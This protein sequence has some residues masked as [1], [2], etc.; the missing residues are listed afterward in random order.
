MSSYKVE[1]EVSN[2]LAKDADTCTSQRAQQAARGGIS[3]GE[4][5][6][7][8]IALRA[9]EAALM[10]VDRVG[11]CGGN[12]G[13]KM[14]PDT[15]L[16]DPAC[17]QLGP[18]EGGDIRIAFANFQPDLVVRGPPSPASVPYRVTD[19]GEQP[20]EHLL[21]FGLEDREARSYHGRA[22]GGSR[23]AVSS[24]ASIELLSPAMI[25]IVE[26]PGNAVGNTK[27]GH[28]KLLRSLHR[29]RKIVAGE[30]R[31][32]SRGQSRV[33]GQWARGRRVP[34]SP[35]AMKDAGYIER[36]D[37]RGTRLSLCPSIVPAPRPR[38]SA[39]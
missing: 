39:G 29:A 16:K 2:I 26:M 23:L 12:V 30:G 18:D 24:L 17:A 28:L 31:G 1:R 37:G 8:W 36:S 3:N 20:R 34:Q 33:R 10:R 9:G 19:L 7:Y 5:H 6:R 35:R 22:A 27:L 21:K 11:R 32:Q 15:F 4:A 25:E 13:A 38:I 14:R